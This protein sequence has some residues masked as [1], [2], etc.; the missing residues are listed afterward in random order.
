M[1]WRSRI[2]RDT[3]P[4]VDPCGD[5]LAQ[6]RQP[7][8]GRVAHAVAHPVAQRLEDCGVGRLS[9]VAHPEVDDLVARGKSCG[10]RVVEAYERVRPCDRSV[11]SGTPGG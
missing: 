7:G 11:E 1:T 9:W 6:L 10:N 2:E 5:R 4:A 3:E 8:G